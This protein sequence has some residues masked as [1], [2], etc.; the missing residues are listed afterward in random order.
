MR[1]AGLETV[2]V[3]LA[4]NHAYLP[5]L[6]ATLVSLVEASAVK[7]GILFHI[8]A[9]GLTEADMEGLRALV[10]RHGYDL[11]LDFRFPDMAP[12]AARFKPYKDSYTA[13]LRLYFAEFFPE[14]DWVLWSDADILWFR[15]P[16]ELW[17]QRDERFSLLW[18]RETPSGQDR[19]RVRFAEWDPDFPVDRYCC[20]GIALMNLKLLR[21]MD[22]PGR[23]A[24]FVARW[25][26]PLLPDQDLLNEFCHRSA[27]IVDDRW[28]C[29]NP[30][31]DWRKGVV[32]HCCG[33]SG[34]FGTMEYD[35]KWPMWA[36]W[37]RYYRQVVRGDRAATVCSRPVRALFWLCG[38][39][40]VPR[41]LIRTAAFWL[42][43]EQVDNLAFAFF[44]AW[45]GRR[46]LW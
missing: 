37:F 12:I 17:S 27:R 46:R 34:F 24:D 39:F 7:D 6:E 28:G 43:N 42:S 44:Y 11:P 21:A 10:R 9:D 20:S 41:R 45:I 36:L 30:D 31:P 22:I 33:V 2:H 25:G 23:S 15:D 3:A 8:F 14:L 26:T 4:A 29:Y 18:G 19:A 40:Y 16:R 38:S 32:L 5:G 13:F 35:D 1:D